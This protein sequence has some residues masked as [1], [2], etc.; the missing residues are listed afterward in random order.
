MYLLVAFECR[1]IFTGTQRSRAKKA[2]EEE[3]TSETGYPLCEIWNLVGQKDSEEKRK[4]FPGRSSP[5]A[6]EKTTQC[7]LVAGCYHW[8]IVI[9]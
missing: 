9:R 4:T 1:K 5:T 8:R 7:L 6:N 3:K 2:S